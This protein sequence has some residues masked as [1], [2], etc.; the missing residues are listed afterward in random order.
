MAI[1]LSTE[2]AEAMPE[3]LYYALNPRL[4]RMYHQ[5]STYLLWTSPVRRLLPYA[6]ISAAKVQLQMGT[7][8]YSQEF[9][10]EVHSA[11]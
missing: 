3:R 6:S 8:K 1:H 9:A 2:D 11:A 7:I 5:I 10:G 4:R